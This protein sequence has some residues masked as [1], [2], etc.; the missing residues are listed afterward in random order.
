[1]T[2]VKSCYL[3]V[4]IF[5]VTVSG[6]QN[7]LSNVVIL[8]QNYNEDFVIATGKSYPLEDFVRISFSAY[9]LDWKK[10]VQQSEDLFKP[11]DLLVGSADPKKAFIKLGWQADVQLPQLLKKNDC[12]LI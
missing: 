12:K 5:F 3:V 9:E 10:Y 2:L 7:T 11:T 6:L 1:M 8:Q 4:W